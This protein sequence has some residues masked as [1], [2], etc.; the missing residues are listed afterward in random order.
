MGPEDHLSKLVEQDIDAVPSH[1]CLGQNAL[2]VVKD[3]SESD[4]YF[5]PTAPLRISSLSLDRDANLTWH[6]RVFGMRKP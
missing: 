6:S 4:V 1:R 2:K 5:R 3:V